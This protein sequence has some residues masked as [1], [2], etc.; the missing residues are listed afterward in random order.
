M[1]GIIY[2][3]TCNYDGRVYIGQTI[4][5]LKRRKAEHIK[6][7]K[8]SS[9]WNPFHTALFQYNFDFTWEVLNEFEG[10]EEYVL[11]ALNVAEEYHILVCNSM[12]E[13]Y[14]FN[15]T[16]GGYSSDKF[17]EQIKRKQE[18]FRFLRGKCFYQYDLDGNYLRTFNSINE[19][20]SYFNLGKLHGGQIKTVG[21]QWKGYQWRENC[22]LAP[23]MN[24]GKYEGFTPIYPVAVYGSDGKFIKLYERLKDAK[25]DTG[26]RCTVRDDFQK[27]VILPYSKRDSVLFYR[28]RGGEYPDSVNVTIL[29]IPRERKKG[30]A[31]VLHKYDAYDLDGNFVARYNTQVEAI[32]ATGVSK[33]AIKGWCRK[34][35]PL[36]VAPSAKML[37]R[38]GDGEIRERIDVIPFIPKEK[39]ES[40]MEHRVLQYSLDGHYLATYDNVLKASKESGESYHA[41]RKMC[42]GGTLMKKPIYQWRNYTDGYPIDIDPIKLIP[43]KTPV[44]KQKGKRG[45][46]KKIV[47]NPGQQT[48]F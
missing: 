15:S 6:D 39:Y 17:S 45:R 16:Q 14:G 25:D 20:A 26:S 40:R 7:A 21:H 30:N 22:G 31:V 1:K 28:V 23:K 46:P 47:L 4:G 35:E 48:L 11:H 27:P 41:I 36:Q 9:G 29:P 37:W 38:Y 2:K 34:E 18:G 13:K 33:D 8:C 3:A 24:I 10:D 12:D 5:G 44:P 32:N 19:I 42:E 43:R